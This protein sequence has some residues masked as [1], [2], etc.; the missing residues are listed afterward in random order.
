MNLESFTGEGSTP[1]RRAFWNKVTQ[2]VVASQKTAAKNVSVAE[3][4]GM[5]TVVNVDRNQGGCD[6]GGCVCIDEIEIADAGTGY[7]VG[8]TLAPIFGTACNGDREPFTIHVD[9]VDG[10]GAVTS[11]IVIAGGGYSTPP[12]NP[13]TFLGSVFGSGF[14]GNCS[15]SCPCGSKPAPAHVE[16]E[17]SGVIFDCGCRESG[18]GTSYI[19]EDSMTGFNGNPVGFQ[20][21]GSWCDNTARWTF[22]TESGSC[23]DDIWMTHATFWNDSSD[24]STDPDSDEDVGECVVH[25]FLNDG[26]YRLIVTSRLL[27]FIG[28]KIFDGT[29]TDLSIPM[30]NTVDCSAGIAHGGTAS[31][32]II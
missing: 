9:T 28:Y 17:F 6:C 32:T 27:G 7:Q 20:N 18:S 3:H 11:V 31:V 26:V 23:P 1:S 16:I 2:A 4:Q 10:S 22:D 29:T 12:S 8:E 30:A 24:C 14:T 19:L 21:I 13:I 5:G 25:F 15:F